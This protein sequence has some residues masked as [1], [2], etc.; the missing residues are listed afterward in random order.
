MRWSHEE[1]IFGMIP[2]G[3]RLSVRRERLVRDPAE[4][5]VIAMVRVMYSEGMTIRE[6]VDVLEERDVR[7]RRGRPFGV[8]GVH[9]MLHTPTDLRPAEGKRRA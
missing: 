6:I 1:H 5:R 8:A 3:W 9:R 7:T 2:Y 4:Q